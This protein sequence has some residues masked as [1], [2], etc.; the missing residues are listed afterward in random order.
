[1]AALSNKLLSILSKLLKDEDRAS[2]NADLALNT[3]IFKHLIGRVSTLAIRLV[4]KEWLK[5]YD[6]ASKATNKDLDLG[7]YDYKLI[8][9]YSLPCRHYLLRAYQIG[10]P[11]PKSLIHPRWWLKGPT[12]RKGAWQSAYAQEKALI[13]L[14]KR[15]DIYKSV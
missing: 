3:A 2:L 4:E 14:P 7:K 15:R 12:I 1:V 8:A 10:L 6:I 13:L 5:L 9:R 11:L